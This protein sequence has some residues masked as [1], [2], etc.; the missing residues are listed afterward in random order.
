MPGYRR[1]ML[2]ILLALL[3]AGTLGG[4]I[5]WAIAQ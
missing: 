2:L 1:L 3:S 5:L 4:L